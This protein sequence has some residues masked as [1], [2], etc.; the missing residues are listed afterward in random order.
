MLALT[1]VIAGYF[2]VTGATSALQ[3]R[4]LS[5]R[6]DRL[7]AEISDVQERY[8]RLEAL[9]QYLDSNEYTEAVAREELGLVR[10]GETSIVV[11]P[12]V[13]SPTPGPGEADDGDLWWEALIR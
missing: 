10:Q 9:R 7:Q 4:Q 1:A 12:T 2:L 13:A 8:E 3:S 5:E 11:I 6:E